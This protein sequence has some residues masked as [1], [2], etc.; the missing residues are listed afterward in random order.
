MNAPHEKSVDRGR[1]RADPHPTLRPFVV[2]YWALARDLAAMGGFTITPDRFGELICC[3]DDLFVVG[4][5]GEE[6]LP[7]CF[8]VGL[9]DGPLRIESPGLVRCMA[10]RLQPWAVGQMPVVLSDSP[11]RGWSDAGRIF[12][13]RLALA[14]EMVRRCEWA[15]LAK[16]FD[17]MLMQEIAGWSTGAADAGLTE[18][19]LGVGQRPTAAVARERRITGRQVERRVPQ[20]D[21]DLAEAARLF[22]AIS[23]GQGCDLGRPDDRPGRTRDRC[24]LLGS[25]PHDEALPTVFRADAGPVRPELVREEKMARG[26]GCRVRSRRSGGRRVGYPHENQTR[27]DQSRSGRPRAIQAILSGCAGYGRRQPTISSAR[28][29]LSAIGR[30]RR[31]ARQTRRRH[32]ARSRRA[33]WSWDF[34]VD[35]I[36]AMK[37]RLVGT[38]HPRLPR[39]VDGMG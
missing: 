33:R 9:L 12:G 21:A 30:M 23:E 16:M 14:S 8:L 32:P 29:R 39:G 22:V 38:R 19:F 31:D 4:D 18:Q 26:R 28:L 3:V 35:D 36:A 34:E 1:F 20:A 10:A 5:G 11:S 24:R 17:E 2:E 7:T 15:H 25:A 37:A 13:P 6:K 27:L